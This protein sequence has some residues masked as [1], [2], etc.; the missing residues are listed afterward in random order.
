MSSLARQLAPASTLRALELLEWWVAGSGGGASM[1][2]GDF[3]EFWGS[4]LGNSNSGPLPCAGRPSSTE[5]HCH[6]KSLKMRKY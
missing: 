1:P 2:I 3:C 4:G 5:P 6:L